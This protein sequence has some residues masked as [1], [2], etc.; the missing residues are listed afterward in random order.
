MHARLSDGGHASSQ[1]GLD[2][3]KLPCVTHRGIMYKSAS[4][5]CLDP[6]SL[7]KTSL[8]KTAELLA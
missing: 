3:I 4:G 1:G 7:Y 8:Y 2:R 5:L 6:V